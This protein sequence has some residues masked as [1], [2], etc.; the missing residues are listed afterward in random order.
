MAKEQ[1]RERTPEEKRKAEEGLRARMN[2]TGG[3]RLIPSRT[4]PQT[5]PKKVASGFRDRI[6]DSSGLELL[7]PDGAVKIPSEASVSDRQA[8][9]D[10]EAKKAQA[11][12]APDGVDTRDSESL[13]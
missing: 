9:A 11:E 7:G 8:L 10:E 2:D 13:S 4:Q 1:R 3:M 12:H 5:T 6:T